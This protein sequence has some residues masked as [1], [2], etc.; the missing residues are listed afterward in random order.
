MSWQLESVFDPLVT[1]RLASV[2]VSGFQPF[3]G[4]FAARDMFAATGFGGG[5]AG[6]DVMFLDGKYLAILAELA[7]WR[8]RFELGLATQ[9]SF[10]A[11]NQIV[12]AHNQDPG[13][14]PDGIIYRRSQQ[15]AA[16][17]SLA[18][19]WERW[20]SAPMILHEFGHIYG[21]HELLHLRAMGGVVF[22]F[23]SETEDQADRIAGMLMAKAGVPYEAAIDA[24]DVLFFYLA[25]RQSPFV[26]I[27]NILSFSFQNTSQT[28]TY[29]PPATRKSLIEW[30]YREMEAEL[31]VSVPSFAPL[32]AP[33]DFPAPSAPILI[34]TCCRGGAIHGHVRARK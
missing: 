16:V 13:L 21:W 23:P 17:A 26:Q 12:A 24:Y 4:G 11:I 8:A 31:G 29:S 25:Q 33:A 14:S 27:Q 6:H 32:F 19:Q 20:Y 9:G 3:P 22:L 15:A 28:P 30:G 2:G 18:Q 10:D 34:E 5:M 7:T 1:G